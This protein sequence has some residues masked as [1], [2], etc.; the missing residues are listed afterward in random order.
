MASPHATTF[1]T[2]FSSC[3]RTSSASRAI[4]GL[5]FFMTA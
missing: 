5:R 1:A 4:P 3:R 2:S